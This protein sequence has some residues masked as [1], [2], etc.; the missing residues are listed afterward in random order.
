MAW[1]DADDV[2]DSYPVWRVTVL[3]DGVSTVLWD[4]SM[5]SLWKERVK[6]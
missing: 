1:S 5:T 2:A 3:R 4:E 6:W